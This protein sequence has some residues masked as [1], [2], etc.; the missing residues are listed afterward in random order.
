MPKTRI[1]GEKSKKTGET[2]RAIHDTKGKNV[3][4]AKT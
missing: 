4:T 2:K 3:K 1:S